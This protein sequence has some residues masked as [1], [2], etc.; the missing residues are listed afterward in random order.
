MRVVEN[1]FALHIGG[2]IV[3]RGEPAVLDTHF[4]KFGAGKR[5]NNVEHHLVDIEFFRLAESVANGFLGFERTAADEHIEFHRH[6][7][8]FEQSNGL[9][10]L[11]RSDAFLDE[12][13]NVVVERLD[14]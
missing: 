7:I 3:G 5:R 10:D 12:T 4:I 2:H 1:R 11:S 9:I 6:T 14:A 8:F 13:Q